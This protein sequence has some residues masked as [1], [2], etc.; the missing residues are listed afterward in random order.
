MMEVH[1]FVAML[2]RAGKGSKDIK[3]SVNAA[4]GD[5]AMSKSQI[6]CIIKA[7]KECKTPLISTTPARRRRSG[8][9]TI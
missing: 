9:A 2:A 5:K 7:V 1:N 8:P 6:N 3:S 4:F